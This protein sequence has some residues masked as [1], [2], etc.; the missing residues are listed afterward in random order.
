MS[1]LRVIK[2]YSVPVVAQ[3]P[4]TCV[5]S[6]KNWTEINASFPKKE[7]PSYPSDGFGNSVTS[8]PSNRL[9]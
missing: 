2:F 3:V 4:H 5:R 1:S 9:H 8:T 7:G 6:T